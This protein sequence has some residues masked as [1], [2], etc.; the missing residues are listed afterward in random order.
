MMTGAVRCN[1]RGIKVKIRRTNTTG[2]GHKMDGLQVVIDRYC[3]VAGVGWQEAAK[4]I[5]SD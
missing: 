2:A 4:R 3:D 5:C 1:D